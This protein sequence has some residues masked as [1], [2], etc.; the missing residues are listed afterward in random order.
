MCG[1]AVERNRGMIP[2]NSGPKIMLNLRDLYCCAAKRSSYAAVSRQSLSIGVDGIRQLD[3]V[4][5]T[6]L[7]GTRA[8]D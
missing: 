6:V 8:V 5:W 2:A 7:R 1:R 4:R 3:G